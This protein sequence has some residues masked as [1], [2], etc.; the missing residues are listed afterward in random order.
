MIGAES[1]HRFGLVNPTGFSSLAE[2]TAIFAKYYSNTA[3]DFDGGTIQGLGGFEKIMETALFPTSIE[4]FFGNKS[5]LLCAA[6]LPIDP[7]EIVEGIVIPGTI[8]TVQDPD[9]G[10]AFSYRYWYDFNFGT[11]NMVLTFM[12]GVAIGVAGQ[13]VIVET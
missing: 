3:I 6:R 7:G 10:L 8:E 13:G 11:L 12:Y 5:A 4:G 1:A 9:T 2:D